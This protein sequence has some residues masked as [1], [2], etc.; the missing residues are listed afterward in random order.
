M[1]KLIV[2]M[3]AVAIA[4]SAHAVRWRNLRVDGSNEG[5]FARSMTAFKDELSPQREYV[6]GAALKDIWIRSATAASYTDPAGDTAK[7]RNRDARVFK[8]KNPDVTA[9]PPAGVR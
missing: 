1:L 6:F 9:A 7:Q 5:A 2:A 3:L 4:G 8:K